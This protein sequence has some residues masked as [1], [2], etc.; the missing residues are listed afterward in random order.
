MAAVD[1]LASD[2]QTAE[3]LLDQATRLDAR[4]DQLRTGARELAQE[5]ARLRVEAESLTREPLAVLPG[6]SCATRDE[7]LTGRITR[8][9]E[10]MGP[11]TTAQ[12]AEHLSISQHRARVGLTRLEDAERIKRGGVGSGT[13]WGLA[14]DASLHDVHRNA[15]AYT[16]VRDAAREL[17]TF[18]FKEISDATPGISDQSLRLVLP[19]LEREEIL[20]STK[21]GREKLYDYVR[22]TGPTPARPR[23]ETP[24]KMAMRMAG[25]APRRGGIVE[26]TGSNTKISGST[27]VNQLARQVREYG[28]TVRKSKH[29]VEFVLDGK[30]IAHSS[31]T[32]GASA[33]GG[34]RKQLR[35][36]GVPV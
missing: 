12:I 15:T 34:T 9:I 1:S 28:V 10:Q 8:L 6:H 5:A 22:P 4:A 13:I 17:G 21:V 31:R 18:T 36:A 20:D 11:M 26:G 3:Q 35:N 25:P 16:V 14:D 7:R 2:T 29:R 32:P 27:I 23:H 24:E 19:R 30:V 33:L